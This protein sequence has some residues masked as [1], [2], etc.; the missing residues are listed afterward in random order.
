M[1]IIAAVLL[2]TC[3][4]GS[5]SAITPD[6]AGYYTGKVS[7]VT[8]D[9]NN[10]KGV[11]QSGT[12]IMLINM[13]GSIFFESELGGLSG[14]MVLGAVRGVL[15]SGDI[16]IRIVLKGKSLTGS[17]SHIL[18]TAPNDGIQSDTTFKMK[19]APMPI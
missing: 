6:Q 18:S 12:A 1:K 15:K 13:D 7:S 11:S 14:T 2:A 16:N 17:H 3:L 8:Y 10:K 5:V 9:F 4:T 19:K